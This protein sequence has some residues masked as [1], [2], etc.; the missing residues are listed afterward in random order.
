MH[1]NK[2]SNKDEGSAVE[3]TWMGGRAFKGKDFR[4]HQRKYDI[5]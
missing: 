3:G 5:G 2:K 4:K 1:Q